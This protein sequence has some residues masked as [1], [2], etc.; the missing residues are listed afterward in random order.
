MSKIDKYAQLASDL[1]AAVAAARAAAPG[2]DGGTCNFDSLMLS[3]PRWDAAK[4]EE[5]AKTA[6][7]R[8]F[9][10]TFCRRKVWVFTV[11]CGG[12]AEKYT[13]QAEAMC[14]T[15]KAAGYDAHVWYRLD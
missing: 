13:R 1:T 8:A 9:D 15:M 3:L 10:S 11:P 2:P 14:K 4:I 6:G 12:Q 5:A 7:I